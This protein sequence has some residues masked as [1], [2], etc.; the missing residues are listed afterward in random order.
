MIT[1]SSIKT[2]TEAVKK[3]SVVRRA[4]A[5]LPENLSSVPNTH[6]VVYNCL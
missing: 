1:F 4:L 3:S 6:M 5:A 2:T